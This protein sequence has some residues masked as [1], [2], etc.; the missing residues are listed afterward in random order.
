MDPA[1]I[2][3]AYSYLR[4]AAPGAATAE[5]MLAEE[6]VGW[7]LTK[8]ELSFSKQARAVLLAPYVYAYDKAQKKWVLA[9]EYTPP[10]DE[11]DGTPP[12]K[13]KYEEGTLEDALGPDPDFDGDTLAAQSPPPKAAATLPLWNTALPSLVLLRDTKPRGGGTK[14][15][16]IKYVWITALERFVK[17]LDPTVMLKM[18]QFDSEFNYIAELN[19][20]KGSI[21]KHLFRDSTTLRRYHHM[22]FRPGGLETNEQNREYNSWRDCGIEPKE[23]DT[24]VWNTHL[25]YL[26]PDHQQRQIVL[27]WCAWILQNPSKKPKHGIM[28]IGTETGT[29]KSLIVRAMEQIVGEK[30]TKRPKNTSMGGEFNSWLA[31]CRLCI[32][33]ELHQ[34]GQ[35]ERMNALRDI[36]TEPTVEVNIKGIPAY[37]IPNYVCFMAISN[38]TDAAPLYS[39]DRRWQ[40]VRTWARPRSISYYQDL[41][42][43]LPEDS[44]T[45]AKNPEALRAIA[46]ELMHRDLTMFHP[47]KEDDTKPGEVMHEMDPST[48]KPVLDAIGDPVVRVY[49]G[50]DR[51][52]PTAAREEMVSLSRSDVESWLFEAREDAPFSW[53]LLTIED[54]LEAISTHSSTMQKQAR[55]STRLIPTFLENEAKGRKIRRIRLHGGLKRTLWH[56]MGKQFRVGDRINIS[57]DELTDVQLADL[58]EQQK[59]GTKIT[60]PESGINSMPDE[61]F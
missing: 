61:A 14:E 47:D 51:P 19:G 23:G 28:L 21:S 13:P 54:I 6:Q 3:N 18:T 40:V 44:N 26:F 57:L 11:P 7:D 12:T 58:Y 30:N 25:N 2:A 52:E 16:G 24:S 20:I 39:N 34:T 33:E 42:D 55:T 38:H 8:D 32:I 22:A 37:Q 49:S 31:N 43:M 46:W 48:G 60:K 5:Y 41:I 45:P 56:V 9:S 10:E 17:R 4:E 59:S 36:V 15:L 1:K 53:G 35:W 50:H 29:G 27:N